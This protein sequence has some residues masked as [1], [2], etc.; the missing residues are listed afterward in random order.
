VE[1]G[2][3]R[4][5]RSVRV[6]TTTFDAFAARAGLGR[7]DLL[8]IDVEGAEALVLRGMERTLAERPPRL[9]VCETTPGDEAARILAARGYTV[10]P[11]DN[12]RNGHG[13]Y[14][15]TAPDAG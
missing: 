6:P 9:V 13:N 11:L 14:L 15:F 10:R 8:K 7:V 5:D 12:P 1:H 4:A 2:V 3:I